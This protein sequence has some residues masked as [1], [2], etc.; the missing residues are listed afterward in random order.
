[1]AQP[2]N[3][4]KFAFFYMLSLVALIFMALSAGMIV[5]QLINKLIK[6]VIE[7]YSGSFDS[8][9]LKFAISA[10]IISTPIYY[11][12]ANQ[13]YKNLYSGVLDKDSGIRRWL[14]Y[15][16]LFV[17][18]V[19]MIG[20]LIGTINTY[21][22]GDLTLKFGLKALTALIIAGAAFGFYFFDIKRDEVVGKK[23]MI[24]KMFFW[25]SL[26]MVVAVFVG[27][28]FIVES[29]RETRLKKIDNT[30][31]NM[32]NNIDNAVVTYFNEN[33]KMPISIEE[34]DNY[35][36]YL[37]AE[38]FVDPEIGERFVYNVVAAEKYELCAT[39]RTSNIDDDDLQS[40]YYKNRWPHDIGY[41]C[42]SQWVGEKELKAINR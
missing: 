11:F 19:V 42:L 20:W 9:F 40:E 8:G 15:F 5:F 41:Q 31:L 23:D 2:N 33:E 4:A 27:S 22:D 21:L 29:P 10:I 25:V 38:D 16:I 1:M 39:F 32:F 18:S 36:A 37:K 35:A 30:V 14:T 17:S 7:N 6:D 26:V 34:I 12:T 28:L 24:I 13:I 3:N